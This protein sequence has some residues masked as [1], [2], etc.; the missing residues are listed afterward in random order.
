M[1]R[2]KNDEKKVSN[3]TGDSICMGNADWKF[4]GDTVKHF[5]NHIKKSVPFY[6][7]GQDLICKLSDFFV[8]HD[9]VCYEIGCSLGDLLLKLVKHNA[10]KPNVQWYGIDCE[11]EM[12]EAAENKF[13]KYANVALEK[14][15]ISTYEFQKS[16][17]IVSYYCIQF[18]H[19]KFRQQLISRIYDRLDWGGAFIWF[20]KVRAPDARFQDITT[21]LYTDFKLERGYSADE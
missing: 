14:S 19:P 15:D 13:E 7:E 4:S 11:P 5:R 9:S 17:M 10:H 18:V 6:E 8:K 12:I 21:S 2:K 20:E 3:N 16:D 1:Q